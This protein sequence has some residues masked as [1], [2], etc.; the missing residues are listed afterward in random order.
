MRLISDKTQLE[1]N[2]ETLEGYITEGNENEVKG[3]IALVKRGTCFVAYQID[4]ELRFA[5]S[6]FIGYADNKLDIHKES[7]DKDGRETNKAIDSILGKKY[8]V[9][10]QLEAKYFDYCHSLGI[11]PNNTGSFGAQRKF[12]KIQIEK[13][14]KSNIDLTGEFPEGKLV[15]RTH[16]SRE[17]NYQVI[18]LAKQNF[19]RQNG[20]LYCQICNFNFETYYGQIGKDF[21]EGHHTIAVCDMTPE[22]KTKVEDIAILCSNCHRIVHKKRPWLSMSELK[23]ILKKK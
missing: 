4:N 6:R 1:Q 11:Q 16:K 15:E 22:H 19:K 17:R 12:W 7:P 14:F 9:D 23:E 5:P 8:I 2:L 18:Q 21:I 3:A 20:Q 13:E 10:H